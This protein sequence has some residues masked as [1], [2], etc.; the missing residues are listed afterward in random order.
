MAPV[1]LEMPISSTP[2]QRDWMFS[3]VMSGWRPAN[4]P[5]SAA[6]VASNMPSIE[7]TLYFTPSSFACSSASSRLIREV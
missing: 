2:R 6:S 7:I 1:L 3:S 5:A 4:S